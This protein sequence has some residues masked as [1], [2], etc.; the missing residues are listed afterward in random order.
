MVGIGA[1]VVHDVEPGAMV[2][3]NPA[4]PAAGRPKGGVAA[5]HGR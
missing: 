5:L 3:G 2:Y 4:K 1:V